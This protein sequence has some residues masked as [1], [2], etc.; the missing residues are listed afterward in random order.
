MKRKVSAVAVLAGACLCTTPLAL[1]QLNGYNGV[2]WQN[3]GFGLL[4]PLV[5]FS[6]GSDYN[7]SLR[8][9]NISLG[10][11]AGLHPSSGAALPADDLLPLMPREMDLTVV[12]NRNFA[13]QADQIAVGP[14]LKLTWGTPTLTIDADTSPGVGPWVLRAGDDMTGSLGMTGNDIYNLGRLGTQPKGMMGTYGPYSV[15]LGDLALGSRS[16]GG[17][18][19]VIMQYNNDGMANSTI[20]RN[21]NGAAMFGINNGIIDFEST[22]FFMGVNH[23]GAISFSDILVSPDGRHPP[24]PSDGTVFLGRYLGGTDANNLI[25]VFGSTGMTFH[26]DFTGNSLWFENCYGATLGG[27][28][29]EVVT[30]FDLMPKQPGLTMLGYFTMIQG[31]ESRVVTQLDGDGYGNAAIGAFR[32][33]RFDF[34]QSPTTASDNWGNVIGGYSQSV[35]LEGSYDA[36]HQFIAQDCR[37]NISF[38]YVNDSQIR[39]LGP[40]GPC[41]GNVFLGGISLS[42]QYQAGSFIEYQNCGNAFIGW[43]QDNGRVGGGQVQLTGYGNAFVGMADG[44]VSVIGNGSLAGGYVRG[45]ANVTANG[46]WAVGDSVNANFDFSYAFGNGISTRAINSMR[47]ARLDIGLGAGWPVVA[48]ALIYAANGAYLSSGGIW[49]DASSRDLKNNVEDLSADVARTVLAGLNPVTFEYKA[50]LGDTHVGFIAEDVPDLVATP[51]KKGLSS[52]DIVAV[53]TKVVQEQQKRIDQL[54]AD[55][56]ALKTAK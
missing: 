11:L 22:A 19:G 46:A 16:M 6:P 24:Y 20:G 55:L 50:E 21:V 43:L 27:F 2:N 5:D 56:K 37:G 39:Y 41:L 4:Y 45:T 23:G 1:A 28:Y 31:P 26:G 49:T 51:D 53:L 52:M 35:P 42:Q 15:S 36:A 3:H 32:G 14:G 38:G 29:N 17:S 44:G 9:L 48:N 13:L 8:S 12:A 33:H 30:P 34:Y 10:Q 7:G 40:E 54:E 18:A 25:R 47:I